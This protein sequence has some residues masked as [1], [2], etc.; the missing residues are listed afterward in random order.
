MESTELYLL[1][2]LENVLGRSLKKSK[3]NYAFHCPFC[4]HPKPKLEI[5]IKTNEK[6]ENPFNCWVCGTRGRKVKSLLQLLKTPKDVALGV[7]KYI[8]K[9]E[10]YEEVGQSLVELPKETQHLLTAT[11]TSILANKAKKYLN[12]RGITDLDIR[13]YNIGYTVDG[14][15]GDRIIIPSYNEF[16]QLNYFIS[17]TV[18]E[19]F[20]K[21]KM[22]EI[23]TSDII[24]FES[25]INWN[26]PITLC[27]G[28]FDAMA[29]KR[30]AIPLLGKFLQP[31]LKKKLL[32][33]PVQD[34]YIALD[35]DALKQAYQLSE[36][37]TKLGKNVYLIKL[38]Q[39]DPSEIG[40]E[41]FLEYYNNSK[42][43]DTKTLLEY[44]LATI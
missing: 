14:I 3:T 44:K 4:N 40:F 21:Y 16:G 12:N 1:A 30:N 5:N 20:Q 26:L 29:I 32:Q 22:P 39:G 17:R 43:L 25:R 18:V 15:Y 42:E 23:G 37:L 2:E 6:G 10:S 27:E 38:D 8:K 36:S 41:G 13:N 28:V 24:F 11:T 35:P 7:L 9:G 34:I 33:S 31:A 19:A